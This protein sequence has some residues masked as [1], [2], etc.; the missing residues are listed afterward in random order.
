VYSTSHDL[1]APLASVLGL[2]NFAGNTNNIDE[3]KKYL[4]MMKGR[5]HALDNFIKD[6]T[7]YS[8]NKRTELSSV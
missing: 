4:G 7:N 6:I 8:R 1:R 5:V 3:L 2:I